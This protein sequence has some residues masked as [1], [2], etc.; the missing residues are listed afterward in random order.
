MLCCGLLVL[1]ASIS[2][3]A[4]FIILIYVCFDEEINNYLYTTFHTV[5][6]LLFVSFLNMSH[7]P[8]H[9]FLFSFFFFFL[10]RLLHV[11]FFVF[12]SHSSSTSSSSSFASWTIYGDQRQENLCVV[13]IVVWSIYACLLT[14][15]SRFNFQ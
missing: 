13:N 10:I 2:R 6:L 4:C 14:L 7:H 11:L 1:T 9:L 5:C 8:H 15:W 3:D 12:S